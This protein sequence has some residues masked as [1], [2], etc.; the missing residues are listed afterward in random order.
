MNLTFIGLPF[1]D[2]LFIRLALI[3]PPFIGF[4]FVSA[5]SVLAF[6]LLIWQMVTNMFYLLSQN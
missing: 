5:K 3:Q 6:V 1:I 4:S 2:F